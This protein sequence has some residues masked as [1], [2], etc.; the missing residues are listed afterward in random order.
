MEVPSLRGGEGSFA[1]KADPAALFAAGG[2]GQA[3]GGEGGFH[4]VGASTSGIAAPMVAFK[5]AR[6]VRSAPEGIG[7]AVALGVELRTTVLL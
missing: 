6:S 5:H 4:L 3:G 2:D 1:D 7:F